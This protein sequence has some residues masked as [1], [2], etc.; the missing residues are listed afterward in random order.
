[1]AAASVIAVLL[2]GL[3]PRSTLAQ[4]GESVP[5]KAQDPI[6]QDIVRMLGEDIEPDLVLQWL[7]SSGQRPG[8]LAADDMIA[9]TQAGAPKEMIQRLLELGAQ[10]PAPVSP[11]SRA[12]P[13]PAAPAEPVPPAAPAPAIART[14]AREADEDCCL[15]EF[16]VE[17]KA[18]EDMEGDLTE[19]PERD[20]FLYVN[21]EYLLHVASRGDIAAR[22]PVVVRHRLGP[23]DYTLRLLR[24]L[25]TREDRLGEPPVWLHET[26]V[27]PDPIAFSVEPGADWHLDVRWVQG[28]FSVR[29]PLSW[30]WTRDGKKIAGKS[31]TGAK[32]EDWPHLCDD[33]EASLKDGA[34]SDWRARDWMKKCVRWD[35]LWPSRAASSRADIRAALALDNFEPTVTTLRGL[36]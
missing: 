13:P 16:A 5:V 3:A 25:H 29:G 28:A 20:L 30:Q 10:P 24:E 23:G 7:E 2:L 22:G 4:T 31:R 15:V 8:P 19:A 34:I 9:L 17:Y 12:L 36:D 32:R 14:P 21:G 18:V 6:I 1:M 27:S 11:Q 33:V 26:T 35:D